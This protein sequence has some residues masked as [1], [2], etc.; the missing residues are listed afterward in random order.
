MNYG[1]NF[2]LGLLIGLFSESCF[3]LLLVCGGEQWL[4][5]TSQV[6]RQLIFPQNIVCSQKNH[7]LLL[8]IILKTENAV[9][10][11][12]GIIFLCK[13][14]YSLSSVCP[15]ILIYLSLWGVVCACLS[16]RM[17]GRLGDNL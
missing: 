5:N 14:I 6:E 11:W 17:W 16:E 8:E 13:F 15:S 10:F 12:L 1:I 4:L 9:R 7:L 2:K 3:Y